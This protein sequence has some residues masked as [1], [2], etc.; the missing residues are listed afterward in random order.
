MDISYGA[1]GI[2][3]TFANNLKREFGDEYDVLVFNQ[4]WRISPQKS[5]KALEDYINAKGYKE[6]V[7]LSHSMGAPVVNSYLARSKENR[8]KVSLYAGF[9]PATLGSFDALAALAC[10][11]VYVNNFLSGVDLESLPLTSTQ[12]LTTWW[13]ENSEISSATT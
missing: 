5:A 7:L 9:A 6:V 3:R 11:D 2:Y 4:D 10:P 1:F 8:D 12:S 13:A